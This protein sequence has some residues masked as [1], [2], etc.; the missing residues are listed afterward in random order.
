MLGRSWGEA[1]AGP[2]GGGENGGSVGGARPNCVGGAC[3]RALRAGRMC[4]WVGVACVW[5]GGR[6]VYVGGLAGR[7]CGRGVLVLTQFL[8]VF[9]E[10]ACVCVC[11]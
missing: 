2:D 3:G 5:A 1:P 8:I 6:G 11:V 9:Y 4:G 7:G 10:A